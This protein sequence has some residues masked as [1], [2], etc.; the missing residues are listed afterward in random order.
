MDANTL[1]VAG[2]ESRPLRQPM[3]FAPD[4]PNKYG[5]YWGKPLNPNP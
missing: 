4:F 2:G 1:N 5:F 3:P